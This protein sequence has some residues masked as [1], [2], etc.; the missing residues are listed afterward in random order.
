MKLILSY[1]R[2][3]ERLHALVRRVYGET[4][5]LYRLKTWYMKN[6]GLSN[7]KRKLSI[8]SKVDGEKIIAN[9]I[10]S[11]KPFMFGKYGTVEFRNIF[12]DDEMDSLCLNAGFFPKDKKL[13]RKFRDVYMESSKY[14][15]ILAPWNYQ[16]HFMKKRKLVGSLPNLKRFVPLSVI[17]DS[18]HLWIKALKG[19]KVLVINPFKSTME[20]QYKK[21]SKLK[22]LPE[23][24]SLRII[25][26]V[27]THA[28]EK[29]D[30]FETWFDALEYMKRE[31]DKEDFDIAILGCGA[32]GFPLAAYVKSKGRQAMHLGGCVQLLF[33]II[34]KRWEER[35]G[36]KKYW[37]RPMESETPK[38]KDKV[39]GGCY[40]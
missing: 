16:N 4:F 27:L 32:Y 10:K 33:G 3:S 36:D 35:D 25:R 9:M 2:G 30:R 24:K 40:W 11:D 7:G 29:D 18:D 21:M 15:D 19:K 39:E 12:Y 14:L 22:I 13:L 5:G 8:V 20:A 1:L 26:A 37:V 34:G 23:L 17:G 28:G 38:D 31:I 6:V